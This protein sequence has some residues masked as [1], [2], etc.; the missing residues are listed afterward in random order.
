MTSI[1]PAGSSS[2]QSCP[3]LNKINNDGGKKR[4]VWTTTLYTIVIGSIVG[5]IY[6]LTSHTCRDFFG[7]ELVGVL[8]NDLFQNFQA[9][10]VND[11]HVYDCDCKELLIQKL[12]CGNVV[13][14]PSFPRE[15]AYQ[16]LL[17]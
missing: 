8:L 9:Q 15:C 11:R 13:H 5:K 16:D 14:M 7:C 6:N 4:C 12:H 10:S 1:C 3:Y 17:E 2:P